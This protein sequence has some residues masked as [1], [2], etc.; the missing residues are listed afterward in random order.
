MQENKSGGTAISA[1]PQPQNISDIRSQLDSAWGTRARVKAYNQQYRLYCWVPYA[2]PLAILRNEATATKYADGFKQRVGEILE[3][4]GKRCDKTEIFID[5]A[6]KEFLSKGTNLNVLQTVHNIQTII[7]ANFSSVPTRGK[8]TDDNAWGFTWRVWLWIRQ[9]CV[10]D[11]EWFIRAPPTSYIIPENILWYILRQ[12]WSPTDAHYFGHK[13][14]FRGEPTISAGVYGLSRSATL[15]LGNAVEHM[16]TSKDGKFGGKCEEYVGGAVEQALATCMADAGGVKPEALRD[17]F[18]REMV[19]LFQ[20]PAH[21]F[22]MN[23]SKGEGWYWKGKPEKI[24]QLRECCSSRLISI[25]N[26]FP[27][28][29]SPGVIR[30]M[31]TAL[32]N[33]RRSTQFAAQV[34]GAQNIGES[35]KK[36][37]MDYLKEVKHNLQHVD[38]LISTLGN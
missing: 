22:H 29:E 19:L 21:F 30:Q 35:E 34:L 18:E 32:Y 7:G 9:H 38:D 14:Y 1:S 37:F 24:P 5:D 6:T 2:L 27:L 15:A 10:V 4:W 12:Q 31:Q 36:Y 17:S 25:D 16:P 11:F 3:T 28:G 26:I 33:P 8:S 20:M 23:R 13:L